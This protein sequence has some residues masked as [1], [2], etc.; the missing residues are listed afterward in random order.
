MLWDLLATFRVLAR[1]WIPALPA[2]TAPRDS[3][4][5]ANPRTQVLLGQLRIWASRFSPVPQFPQQ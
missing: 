4:V 3:L 5:R 1:K 2:L